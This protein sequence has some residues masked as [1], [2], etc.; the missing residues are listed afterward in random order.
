METTDKVRTYPEVTGSQESIAEV[1]KSAKVAGAGSMVEGIAGLGT[2]VLAIIGLAGVLPGL[3]AFIATIAIGV[4]LLFQGGAMAARLSS[5]P[6][7]MSGERVESMPLG[8]GMTAEFLGGVAGIVLGILALVGV[9]PVIL[10][11]IAA[12]VFGGALVLGTGVA[13]SLN[14]LEMARLS[15]LTMYQQTAREVVSAAAGMQVFVGLGSITLGILALLGI[16]PL[17]L[18]LV[19]MLALGAA[20]LLSSAA[21]SN[22]MLTIFRL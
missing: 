18:V 21:V 6:V 12:I 9:A 11:A 17:I 2:V 4:A 20:V 7:E 16:A 13:A 19:A 8:G 5:L 10:V 22:R 15:G 1:K 14:S 3:L